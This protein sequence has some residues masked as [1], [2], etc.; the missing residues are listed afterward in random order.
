[1]TIA[2]LE[3]ECRASFSYEARPNEQVVISGVTC[4]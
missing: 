1:V 3:R 4:Q 2:L